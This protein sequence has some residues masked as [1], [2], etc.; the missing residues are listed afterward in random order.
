[1]KLLQFLE[2]PLKIQCRRLQ[3][4][5]HI[6]RKRTEIVPCMISACRRGVQE[7]R[8]LLE[9]YTAY[10]DSFLPTFREY[11]SGLSSRVEQT[12]IVFDPWI[13]DRKVRN[14][15]PTLHESQKEHRFKKLR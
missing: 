4:I 10:N 9:F 3:G 14:K 11:I 5:Q 6:A 2:H 7:I 8:A 12:K 1:M 13:R 15:L